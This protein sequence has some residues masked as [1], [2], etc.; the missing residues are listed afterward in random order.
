MTRNFWSADRPEGRR[1]EL[2]LGHGFGRSAD[3]LI[4][5]A[6]GAMT[7]RFVITRSEPLC[8]RQLEGFPSPTR[9]RLY[10]ALRRALRHE[11]SDLSF[12]TFPLT[13][14]AEAVYSPKLLLIPFLHPNILLLHPNMLR[15]PSGIPG[16]GTYRGARGPCRRRLALLEWELWGSR[17][18]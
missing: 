9:C 16:S 12:L 13:R 6:R 8:Q 18:R 5:R 10:R 17:W 3:E 7:I 15:G 4:L 14:R 11:R 2:F 1:F